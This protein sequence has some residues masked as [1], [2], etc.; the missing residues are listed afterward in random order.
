MSIQAA[1]RHVTRYRYERPI[2]LGAQT[3]RL[4]PA[5]HARAKLSAYALKIEPEGYFLNWQQDPQSNW[6]AR[7][8]FPEKVDHFTITVDL[9]VEMAVINPFDF[10][11]ELSADQYTFTYSGELKAELEPY[12]KAEPSGQ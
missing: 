3:I 6:L 9:T 2:Q 11:L 5:P 10:F 8:E 12:L 1:L 7:V 4:R